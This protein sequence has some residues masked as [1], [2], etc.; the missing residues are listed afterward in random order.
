MKNQILLQGILRDRNGKEAL[1]SSPVSQGERRMEWSLFQA[2]DVTAC[3]VSGSCGDGFD[4]KRGLVLRPVEQK[5][6]VDFLA[7]TAPSGAL[8]SLATICPLS[9]PKRRRFKLS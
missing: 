7:I 8:L 6:A 2:E 9:P 3:R 4:A 5:K 1:F